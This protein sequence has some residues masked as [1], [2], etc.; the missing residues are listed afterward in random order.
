MSFACLSGQI[1]NVSLLVKTMY[2]SLQYIVW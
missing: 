2:S 1:Y